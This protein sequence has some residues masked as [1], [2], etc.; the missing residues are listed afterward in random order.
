MIPR[1]EGNC[2]GSG[3]F[4][5]VLTDNPPGGV[6]APGFRVLDICPG[7]G[8]PYF[9]RGRVDSEAEAGDSMPRKK[10]LKGC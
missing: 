5:V 2:P 8:Y 1:G 9:T 4:P 7:P 6:P 10:I 3:G